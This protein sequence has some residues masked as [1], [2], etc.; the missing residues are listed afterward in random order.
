MEDFRRANRPAM[1][2][3]AQRRIAKRKTDREPRDHRKDETGCGLS[4]GEASADESAHQNTEEAIT[5]KAISKKDKKTLATMKVYEEIALK[6]QHVANMSAS[7]LSDDADVSDKLLANMRESL[8]Y[9]ADNLLAEISD[10]LSEIYVEDEDM[11]YEEN[12][13][14]FASWL[15]PYGLLKYADM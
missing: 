11:G 4:T 1:I 12:N 10:Q 15:E 5:M 3:E 14:V 9:C 8:R 6:L 13:A 2:Q 7:E